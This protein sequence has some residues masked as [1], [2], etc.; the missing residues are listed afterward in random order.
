MESE[1]SCKLVCNIKIQNMSFAHCNMM[2]KLPIFRDEYVNIKQ[3]RQILPEL[4]IPFPSFKIQGVPIFLL[5]T[6][7]WIISQFIFRKKKTSNIHSSQTIY[8]P[9]V[10]IG[11]INVVDVKPLVFRVSIHSNPNICG[12]L[13][14]WTVYI[15]LYY[16]FFLSQVYE[17][18]FF[19]IG[20]TV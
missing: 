4:F 7:Y 2:Q 14:L 8:T 3:H 1:H 19:N 16:F 13:K 12:M 17:F 20:V 18:S 9:F 5:C 10:I 6:L 15:I 11:E